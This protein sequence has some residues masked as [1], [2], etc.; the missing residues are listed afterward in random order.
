MCH[1]ELFSCEGKKICNLSQQQQICSAGII[2][3]VS[4]WGLAGHPQDL[5]L[6]RHQSGRGGRSS[7]KMHI[8]MMCTYNYHEDH[9]GAHM[10]S[11]H[12]HSGQ[13]SFWSVDQTCLSKLVVERCLSDSP[14]NIWQCQ[15]LCVPPP[16]YKWLNTYT[17]L[18]IHRKE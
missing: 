13:Y 17:H 4:L 11:Y 7:V 9:G 10:D 1:L 3:L 6:F 2:T 14:A 15:I 5:K 8:Y 12:E 18:S 16:L